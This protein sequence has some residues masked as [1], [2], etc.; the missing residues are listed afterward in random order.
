MYDNGQRN[1]Y[2]CVCV[3]VCVCWYGERPR[4]KYMCER[5]TKEKLMCVGVS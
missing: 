3:C 5:G 2:V 4:N 1:V